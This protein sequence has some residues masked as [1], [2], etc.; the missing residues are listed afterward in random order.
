MLIAPAMMTGTDERTSEASEQADSRAK[1][2]ERRVRRATNNTCYP[3]WYDGRCVVVDCEGGLCARGHVLVCIMTTT[4]TTQHQHHHHH[5]HQHHHHHHHHH[6]H[7]H[8][9][10]SAAHVRLCSCRPHSISYP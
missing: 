8:R 4:I 2:L 5:E 7:R 9:R 6:R 1:S 3:L 10:C